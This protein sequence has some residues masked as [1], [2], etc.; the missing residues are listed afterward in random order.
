MYNFLFHVPTKVYFGRGQISHLGELS[1]YGKKVLL[2]YGGGS[3]KRNG[4]YDTAV[5]ILHDAGMEIFE[6]AGVEP[7]PKIETVL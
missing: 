6:L 3:I 4:L 7:N 1:E 5:G 2:V